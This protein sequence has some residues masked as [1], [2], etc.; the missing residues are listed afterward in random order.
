MAELNDV[1]FGG[2]MVSRNIMDGRPAGYAFREESSLPQ[3][4]GWTLYSVDD[5][6]DWVNEPSNFVIVG[7]TTLASRVPVMVE[8]FDA[9]C[10]TDLAFTYTEG[11]H[12]G[13]WDLAHDRE[14]SI[15]Q[16][17]AG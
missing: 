13:F 6:E 7:A 5:D 10:G 17:L 15:E 12:T 8:I 9:P 16:I 4:N 1:A 11:V 2:F 14:V 3:L